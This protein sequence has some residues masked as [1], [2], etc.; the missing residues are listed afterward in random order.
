MFCQGIKDLN[1]KDSTIEIPEA[2]LKAYK[3][4]LVSLS[5]TNCI[6]R[7]K[8]GKYVSHPMNKQENK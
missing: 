1:F 5:L 6:H 7:S 4:T 3:Q 2:A 8:Y